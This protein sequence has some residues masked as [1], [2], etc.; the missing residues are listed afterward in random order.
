MDDD[1]VFSMYQFSFS[2]NSL[3]SGLVISKLFMCT[4]SDLITKM[5]MDKLDLVKWDTAL[6]NQYCLVTQ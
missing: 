3:Y 2:I 1:D 5:F 6:E 4:D